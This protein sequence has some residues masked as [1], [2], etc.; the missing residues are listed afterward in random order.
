MWKKIRNNLDSGI[1]KIKWFS[2][3]LNERVK[4]EISLMKLIYQSTELEKKRTDLL[5]AIGERVLE[6]RNNP[7]KQVLRDHII[8]ETLDKL[9]KLD[10][11]MEDLRKKVSEVGRVEV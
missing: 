7:E 10:V 5:K 3:L 2:S 4:I 8:L 11:E 6:L 9:E 1:G